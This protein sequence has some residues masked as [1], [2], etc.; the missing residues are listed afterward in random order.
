MPNGWAL[1]KKRSSVRHSEKAKIFIEKYYDE[2][3]ASGRK[4]DPSEVERLMIEEDSILTS[5]RLTA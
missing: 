2:G 4:Y 1:R 5:E 3:A